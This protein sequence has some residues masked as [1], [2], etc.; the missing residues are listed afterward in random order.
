MH[1]R[2][3]LLEQQS[4]DLA[5][6]TSEPLLLTSYVSQG[7]LEDQNWQSTALETYQASVKCH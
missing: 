4:E 3:G 7:C 6:S 5:S 2:E 1:T